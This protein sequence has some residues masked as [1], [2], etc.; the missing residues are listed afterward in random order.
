MP[1]L[2]APIASLQPE[3][4]SD[5]LR[6]SHGQ[7]P[8]KTPAFNQGGMGRP[9]IAPGPDRLTGWEIDQH[10]D[11][12]AAVESAAGKFLG[13]GWP[14]VT[15]AGSRRTV[16]SAPSTTATTA[17]KPRAFSNRSL[18]TPGGRRVRIGPREEHI[19]VLMME[20]HSF[21]NILGLIGRGD[22]LSL[23][24]NG[25]PT[26][27]NPDGQGNDVHAFHMPT[28]CQTDSVGNDW[29]VTH[30]AFDGGT[31]QGFVTSTSAEAMGY[32]TKED[33]PSVVAWPAHFPSLTGTSARPW[34]RPTRIAAT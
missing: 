23:G 31:C 16:V 13:G 2:W 1:G 6:Q 19:V 28:E 18:P 9:T 30:E 15:G 3:N 11:D 14:G 27:K 8:T 33:L 5:H 25:Q 26:A 32:F 12:R 20:N 34:P 22:G 4:K 24:A 7:R 17:L 10:A 21:D 29:K